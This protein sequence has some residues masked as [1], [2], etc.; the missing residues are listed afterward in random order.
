V[1]QDIKFKTF[2]DQ[3]RAAQLHNQDLEMQSRVQEQQDKHE[4][5]MQTMQDHADANDW[6]VQY[7][8]IANHGDAVMDHL[9]TQTLANGAAAVPPGTHIS[10]DGETI[11]IPQQ[12]P[13]NDA[14]MLKEY[15]ALGSVFNLPKAP[16]GATKL[17]PAVTT[18]YYNLKQ[19]YD[20]KGD[21]Y[22]AD[23]LPGIIQS[24]QSKLD[25][26]NANGGTPAQI[27][28]VKGIIAKQNAQLKADNDQATSS[29]GAQKG[30]E[31]TAENTAMISLV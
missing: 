17:A 2:D 21:V 18:V 19:G 6:G 24:N 7:D 9:R 1:Q 16:A 28:L 3:N 5:H 27:S 10:A 20:A 31:V 13:D 14:A 12:T 29:K 25:D 8:T 30:A 23:K 11:K 22:T 4:D 26:L 15:N